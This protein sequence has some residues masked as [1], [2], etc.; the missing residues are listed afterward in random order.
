MSDKYIVALVGI[1]CLTALGITALAKGIDG[2]LFSTV[3][4]TIGTVLGYLWGISSKGG[5]K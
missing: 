5:S 1:I 4:G 2:A 3:I